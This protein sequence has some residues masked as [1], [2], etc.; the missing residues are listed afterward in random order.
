MRITLEY[1]S[2]KGLIF[3]SASVQLNTAGTTAGRPDTGVQDGEG[4]RHL[5]NE[6][7]YLYHFKGYCRATKI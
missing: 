1:F 5:V 6:N 7:D 2:V 4:G 3:L